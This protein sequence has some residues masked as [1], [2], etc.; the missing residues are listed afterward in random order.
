VALQSGA[1]IAVDLD[2]V[3]VD[4]D[5]I[6]GDL[7]KVEFTVRWLLS[8]SAAISGTV[9]WEVRTGPIPGGDV[10]DAQTASGLD[11]ATTIAVQSTILATAPSAIFVPN[12]QYTNYLTPVAVPKPLGLQYV[13]LVATSPTGVP[14]VAAT[15]SP[16]S[17]FFTIFPS[18]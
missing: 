9:V 2:A 10:I 4:F 18:D 14:G 15:L 12:E 11:P 1:G 16:R 6:P 13:Q 7:I 3:V 8:T 5:A 17:S